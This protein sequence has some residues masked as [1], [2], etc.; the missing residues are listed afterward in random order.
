MLAQG[1]DDETGLERVGRRASSSFNQ[2]RT[3]RPGST[4]FRTSRSG[5]TPRDPGVPRG[6]VVGRVEAVGS[7][8]GGRDLGAVRMLI[9]GASSDREE[10]VPERGEGVRLVGRNR[11]RR[12]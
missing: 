7:G 11:M 1:G 5:R 4:S 12:R 8:Q 6:V 2:D 10:E 9:R 3:G